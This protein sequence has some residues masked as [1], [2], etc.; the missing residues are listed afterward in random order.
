VLECRQ[1]ESEERDT[2]SADSVICIHQIVCEGGT[3]QMTVVA[4]IAAHAAGGSAAAAAIAL[5]SVIMM[6]VA[7]FGFWWKWVER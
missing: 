6:A 3:G 4:M 1:P 7:M 2:T 5:L